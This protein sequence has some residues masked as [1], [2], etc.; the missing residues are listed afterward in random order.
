MFRARIPKEP[1][2]IVVLNV[3]SSSVLRTLTVDGRWPGLV[4]VPEDLEVPFRVE[5]RKGG[6][7]PK[8][9]PTNVYVLSEQLCAA[10]SEVDVLKLYRLLDPSCPSLT[11][12]YEDDGDPLE[13]LVVG[14]DLGEL[15][16]PLPKKKKKSKDAP[17]AS[18]IV[19]QI[20][21]E[22]DRTT[23]EFFARNRENQSSSDSD[24]ADIVPQCQA[25]SFASDSIPNG[26]LDAIVR[27]Q[28]DWE[29][30]FRLSLHRNSARWALRVA[31]QY[32]TTIDPDIIH[33]FAK[34]VGL[35][36]EE[37]A[38]I[39]DAVSAAFGDL[40]ASNTVQEGMEVS[41]ANIQP[42]SDCLLDLSKL[43][44]VSS[45]KPLNLSEIDL[46]KLSC[47][48]RRQFLSGLARFSD[49]GAPSSW[50]QLSSAV[51]LAARKNTVIGRIVADLRPLNRL[52]RP[53]SVPPVTTVAVH[54]TL[55]CG[56][57]HSELDVSNAYPSLPLCRS[58]QVYHGL[59]S[60]L[61][62]IVA[63]RAMLGFSP[64]PGIFQQFLGSRILR[65]TTNRTAVKK[66]WDEIL[67]AARAD[68]ENDEEDLIPRT[69]RERAGF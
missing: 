63:L 56:H 41:L 61:G 40:K 48:L 42:L 33:D 36:P 51:F 5:F 27:E 55:N 28:A 7:F 67:I 4:P 65:T 21:K 45:S 35:H 23:S 13:Q 12:E 54:A 57:V 50:I 19:D 32:A 52:A 44:T 10:A 17:S 3:N 46:I 68:L 49:L 59:S 18:Q 2:T 62:V 53:V 58:L 26:I 24:T 8:H 47:L 69:V 14:S 60:L 34:D 31:E 25:A 66:F 9:L 64:L 6:V 22:L 15:D 20:V 43:H 1:G 29:R 38:G 39:L 30:N 37:L 11:S 16:I